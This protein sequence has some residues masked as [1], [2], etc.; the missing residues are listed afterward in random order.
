[1]KG[2]LHPGKRCTFFNTRHVI[3]VI[4][5]Y[6]YISQFRDNMLQYP[7]LTSGNHYLNTSL[8]L[9]QMIILNPDPYLSLTYLSLTLHYLRDI[10]IL[11]QDM[12][13]ISII[14]FKN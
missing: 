2:I 9:G 12:T 10:L 11:H 13:T 7:S 5:N 4:A 8:I 3:H 1:M 14:H 6:C